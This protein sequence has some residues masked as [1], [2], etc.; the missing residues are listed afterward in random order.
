MCLFDC[1]LLLRRKPKFSQW[2]LRPSDPSPSSSALF[3]PRSLCRSQPHCPPLEA[4]WGTRTQLS[5]PVLDSLPGSL[6]RVSEWFPPPFVQVIPAQPHVHGGLPLPCHRKPPFSALDIGKK[7]FAVMIKLS[8]LRR[9]DYSGLSRWVQC[10]HKG[11][12]KREA[13][14]SQ[15]EK[16]VTTERL[17][18]L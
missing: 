2:H 12:Y 6:P 3:S 14:G 8:S 15:I 17:V 16:D 18:K 13:A 5:P 10:K 11:L 9:G 1:W 4:H 7:V